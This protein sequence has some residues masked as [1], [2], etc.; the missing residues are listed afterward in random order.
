VGSDG[1][2]VGQDS[3]PPAITRSAGRQPLARQMRSRKGMEAER[4]TVGGLPALP[5]ARGN[6]EHH[7][8][9]DRG[10]A[11]GGHLGAVA[12]GE[13]AGFRRPADRGRGGRTAAAGGRP[14]GQDGGGGLRADGLLRLGGSETAGPAATAGACPRRSPGLLQRLGRRDGAFVAAGGDLVAAGARTRCRRCKPGGRQVASR[15]SLSR[16]WAGGRTLP[17]RRGGDGTHTSTPR[18]VAT[19]KTQAGRRS[20]LSPAPLCRTRSCGGAASPHGIGGLRASAGA[21]A[22]NVSGRRTSHAAGRG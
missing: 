4:K 12:A 5:P 16:V 14:F 10:R 9:V 13:S 22:G 15:R 11:A 18:P 2:P 6:H 21:G 8:A 17:P 20:S 1:Q 7:D 19:S 3:G